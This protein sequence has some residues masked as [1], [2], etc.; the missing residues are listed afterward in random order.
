ML[1]TIVI[2]VTKGLDLR[3]DEKQLFL[4]SPAADLLL[5]F[6][7][8]THWTADMEIELQ[9]DWQGRVS[10]THGKKSARCSAILINSRLDYSVKETKRDSKGRVLNLVI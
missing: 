4:F 7:Q 10:Y 8:E 2:K 9:R 1:P 6:L 5:Y 3:I